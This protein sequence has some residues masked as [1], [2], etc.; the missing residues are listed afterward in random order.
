MSAGFWAAVLILVSE[1]GIGFSVIRFFAG[2]Q[3]AGPYFKRMNTLICVAE[4]FYTAKLL[5]V[6][7]TNTDDNITA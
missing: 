6:T 3:P 4:I 7:E 2:N 1:P 5:T